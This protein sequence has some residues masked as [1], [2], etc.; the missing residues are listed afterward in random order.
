MIPDVH[1]ARTPEGVHI[2]YQV[3]GRGPMDLVLIGHAYSNI[4]FLWQLPGV[5]RYLEGLA[6]FARIIQF[7][8]RGVGLSD[9]LSVERLPTI[10]TRMAD[11]L[12][13]MDV[14]GSERAVL[15][16]T[17][18]T[19]P[20][21]IVF[22]ATHPERTTA[23]ILLGTTCCGL[24]KPDYPWPWTVEQWEAYARDVEEGWG[25]PAYI[26]KF[27]RWLEPT[28]V[29]DDATVKTFTTYFRVAASPGAVAAMDR[30]ERDTDVRH[31]LSSVQVPTLVMHRRDDQMYPVEEGRYIAAHIPGARFIEL[32]GSEHLPWGGDSGA[33]VQEI[34]RFL[35]SIRTEEA[36][37][38]RVLATVLF[39]DIVGSTEQAAGAGDRAWHE[40]LERHHAT[41]RAMLVRYHGRE[42]DTAGDGFFATFDGPARAIRCARAIIEAVRVLGIEVRAGL[43]TGEVNAIGDHVRGIAVHIGARVGEFAGA[44]EVFVSHTV[45]DLVAGS[46]LTFEDA[47]EHELKGVPDRWR[48]YRV[49]SR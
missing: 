3:A 9:P 29:L 17:D 40:L 36:E 38:D 42:V 44:S 32:E 21:S 14:M 31:V 35:A 6:S 48:L 27:V 12:A 10:E 46:G 23:L 5:T 15:V 18:A 34:E 25:D 26:E 49:V 19:G 43:H 2:A 45:K 4:Q 16:G 8:P 7:D 24:P 20:L 28:L 39:T 30:M 47:G 11:T 1:Y 37:F 41:V 22:A 13:V 33:L